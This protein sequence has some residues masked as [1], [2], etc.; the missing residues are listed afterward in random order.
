MIQVSGI[1]KCYYASDALFKWLWVYL[2]FYCHIILH[3]EKK[4]SYEKFSRNRTF[5]FQT[6]NF[7]HFND[8]DGSIEM[9][10]NRLISKNFS[11]NEKF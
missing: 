1:E 10:K 9:L 6:G 7:Q 2:L 4:T 11:K 5:E 3:W 8:I